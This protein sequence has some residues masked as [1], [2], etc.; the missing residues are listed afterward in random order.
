MLFVISVVISSHKY[1]GEKK[2]G[3]R[4]THTLWRERTLSVLPIG[5][6]MFCSWEASLHNMSNLL[7]T[8]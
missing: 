1:T 5:K 4:N 8:P 3:V 2:M 6:T 7:K